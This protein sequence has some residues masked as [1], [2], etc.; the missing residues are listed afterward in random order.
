MKCLHDLKI[1]YFQFVEIRCSGHDFVLTISPKQNHSNQKEIMM[2]SV[3]KEA[4]WHTNTDLAICVPIYIYM[5][6][7]M[8]ICDCNLNLTSVKQDTLAS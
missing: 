5:Y 8:Y 1:Y 3:N 7:C 4:G 2:G 6:V